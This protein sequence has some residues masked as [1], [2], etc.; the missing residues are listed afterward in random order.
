MRSGG[1]GEEGRPVR[2]RGLHACM[3]TPGRLRVVRG[4]AFLYAL[5]KAHEPLYDPCRSN[6]L[7]TGPPPFPPASSM[8]VRPRLLSLL[9]L[10]LAL[11]CGILESSVDC[12]LQEVPGIWV[13]VESAD[14]STISSAAVTVTDGSGWSEVAILDAPNDDWIALFAF[15]RTGLYDISVV[16]EGFEPWSRED[17]RVQREDECHVATTYV[18]VRLTPAG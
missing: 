17:V 6:R 1:G 7:H 5:R 4:A 2:R 3:I 9:L 13:T 16:A 12:T 11:G 18:E 15:E 10:P 14:G 8:T